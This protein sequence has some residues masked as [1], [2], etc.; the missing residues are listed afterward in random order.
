MQQLL[1][2]KKRLP[3]FKKLWKKYYLGDLFTQRRE[4]NG[5]HLPLLAITGKRGIILASEISRKDSSNPDKSNYKRIGPGD[6]GYNTMRMWQGVS[7]VSDIE[8]IVSPAYTICKPKEGVNVHF[9]GYLFKLPSIVHLF[10]SYSQGLVSDTLNLKF[11]HFV[12]IKIKIPDINEQDAI[13]KVLS[14]E[15]IEIRAHENKLAAIEKQKRGLMQKLLTG[16][17]RVKT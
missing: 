11:H 13:V 14:A 5:N 9:M 15:D 3:G 7:A 10:W 12:Q 2:G 4:T 16:E 8:G 6:I 1:I 17:V